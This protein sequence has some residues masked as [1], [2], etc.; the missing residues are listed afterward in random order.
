MW[1]SLLGGHFY[2]LAQS[3]A[4]KALQGP[5][6]ERKGGRT[7]GTN[8]QRWKDGED[9]EHR[10]YCYVILYYKASGSM[11]ETHESFG[12]ELHCTKQE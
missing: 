4:L 9:N 11:K 10:L 6:T 12:F 5:E 8:I 3:Q 2:S 7:E 1:C